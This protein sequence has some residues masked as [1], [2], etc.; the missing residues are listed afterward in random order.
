MRTSR[1]VLCIA[2]V[3][4]ATGCGPD[5]GLD[6]NIPADEAAM[7]EP[8]PLVVA[9][10]RAEAPDRPEPFDFGDRGWVPNAMP[11]RGP[12]PQSTLTSV[13]SAGDRTLLAARWDA[14]PYD[15]IFVRTADGALQ[16]FV[17]LLGVGAPP[18]GAPGESQSEATAT[19]PRSR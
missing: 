9:T 12:L 2:L 17:P 7:K 4:L 3:T 8:K 6:D 19:P 15:R 14:P 13:G 1:P 11:R 16:E 18:H 10:L 5:L